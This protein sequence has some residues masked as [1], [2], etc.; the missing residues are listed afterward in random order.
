M[1]P[2]VLLLWESASLIFSIHKCRVAVG[3]VTLRAESEK[4]TY[5]HAWTLFLPWQKGMHT[6]S[7][8]LL[9]RYLH[10]SLQGGGVGGGQWQTN[11]NRNRAY[12]HKSCI[13]TR[14]NMK[15]PTRVISNVLTPVHLGLDCVTTHWHQQ[16]H[17][18]RIIILLCAA[19]LC[20]NYLQP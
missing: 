2:S 8:H 10:L 16:E 17:Q 7:L 11:R 20:V 6:T 9:Q 18:G 1:P 14:H 4:W 13:Y 3:T 5:F 12:A 19:G 15:N